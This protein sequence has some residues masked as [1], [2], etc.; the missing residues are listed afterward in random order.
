MHKQQSN[1][2]ILREEIQ[3]TA[4]EVTRKRQALKIM[5]RLIRAL[6]RFIPHVTLDHPY[7][8]HFSR[9]LLDKPTLNFR[10]VKPEGNR[11]PHFYRTAMASLR[12]AFGLQSMDRK[13]KHTGDSNF[14]VWYFEATTTLTGIEVAIALDLGCDVPEGCERRVDRESRM[15]I[16]RR[17]YTATCRI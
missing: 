1:K 2:Q 17:S 8:W 11:D 9:E 5:R 10:Q 7:D 12:Q 15:V 4:E 3:R 14:P 16:R 6:P 13:M